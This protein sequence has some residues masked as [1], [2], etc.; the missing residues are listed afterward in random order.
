MK[1]KCRDK[2]KLLG[3]RIA[4]AQ[5]D[6]RACI[7]IARLRHPGPAPAS[8]PSRLPVRADPLP[9]G[10]TLAGRVG[11]P[12]VGRPKLG[13]GPKARFPG[14][15]TALA[16]LAVARDRRG[17]ARSPTGGTQRAGTAHTHMF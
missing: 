12:V 14:Q 6:E 15:N 17:Y 1:R 5:A 9:F 7:K 2:A 8:A 10:S 13:Q 16:T 3:W 11:Q 4:S